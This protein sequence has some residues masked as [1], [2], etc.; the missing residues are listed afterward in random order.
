MVASMSACIV[1]NRGDF[2]GLHL[3]GR[4]GRGNGRRVTPA[5]GSQRTSFARGRSGIV[6][7][8]RVVGGSGHR[9]S[10]ILIRI[11]R[12]QIHGHGRSWGG[13]NIDLHGLRGREELGRWLRRQ[14]VAVAR[15]CRKQVM[16]VFRSQ[17]RRRSQSVGSDRGLQHR[18]HVC[19]GRVQTSFSKCR[20]VE[21]R[22]LSSRRLPHSRIP[23]V[24]RL[25]RLGLS[26]TVRTT[27]AWHPGAR[28]HVCSC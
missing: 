24:E 22:S 6:R 3:V 12:H 18:R 21:R 13:C 5:A 7:E 16:H 4:I 1:R 11:R 27:I 17:W 2:R 14:A 19:L 9:R 20:E 8:A 28:R 25:G 23:R 26:D 10:S 15:R